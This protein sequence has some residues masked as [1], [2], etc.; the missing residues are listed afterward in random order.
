MANI[1]NILLEKEILLESGT[2]EVEVLVFRVGGFALGINVAKVREVLPNQKIT[3][4]PQSHESIVG[5][6]TL[7]DQVVPC[8]SLHKHLGEGATSE[9]DESTIIL[10]EFNQYQT[11]FIV[12]SVE[13]I[14]RISWQ[15]VLAAPSIVNNTET[16]VTAVTNIEDRLILMLDFEMIADQV[17]EK[18][19]RTSAVENPNELPREQLKILLAD[20]SATVRE[21]AAETLRS[22][23]YTNLTTFEN[24]EEAWNWI[25]KQLDTTGDASQVANLLISDVEMPRIDGFHL[26][27]NIKEHPELKNICVLLYSSILTPDNRN[28]GAAVKADGMITKPELPRLV[29]L[30]DELTVK[31]ASQENVV[32]PIKSPDATTETPAKPTP[33]EPETQETVE[34]TESPSPASEEDVKPPST[35]PA[36]PVKKEPEVSVAPSKTSKPLTES[37]LW[38]TFRTELCERIEVLSKLCQEA[39]DEAPTDALVNDTF[40]VLHS[41][42][43][44]AMVAPIQEVAQV[45]HSAE[46][47]MERTRQNTKNWPHDVMDNYTDW[48]R[49]LADPSNDEEQVQAVLATSSQLENE[50]NL[51]A[52]S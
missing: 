26:T 38:G 45:T 29:D 12:D 51:A 27:K 15:D 1:G 3:H 14:H 43:S 19:H 41:I 44:A 37:N 11:A 49:D 23:G 30:A 2:N 33:S 52:S 24:G 50:M 7:R 42:K 17:S 35:T 21:A 36:A 25:Q 40:R 22:S 31:L 47:M 10:T 13:R 16:P 46:N 28:K 18:A 4:L 9:S 48:L 5:C 32:K 34:T 6:F 39:F 20:D 8:V